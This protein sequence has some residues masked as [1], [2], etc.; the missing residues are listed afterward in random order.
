MSSESIL[1]SNIPDGAYELVYDQGSSEYTENV[2]Y[3][4]AEFNRLYTRQVR[5]PEGQGNVL[6]I[7]SPNTQMDLQL[8]T[9]SNFIKPATWRRIFYPKWMNETYMGRRIKFQIKDSKTR[10]AEIKTKTKLLPFGG[11]VLLKGSENV[12]FLTSDIFQQ[13]QPHENSTVPE[14]ELHPELTKEVKCQSAR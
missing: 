5:L 10:D 14:T 7:L 11:R 1:F 6:Y 12:I 2:K 9:D 3:G 4:G 13:I 8:L